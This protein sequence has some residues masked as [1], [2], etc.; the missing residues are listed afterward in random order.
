M[1]FFLAQNNRPAAWPIR[2]PLHEVNLW[3]WDLQ[4]GCCHQGNGLEILPAL[5]E[6]YKLLQHVSSGS[7]VLGVRETVLVGKETTLKTDTCSSLRLTLLVELPYSQAGAGCV[8]WRRLRE[9]VPLL[10]TQCHAAVC[11]TCPQHHPAVSACA[12]NKPAPVGGRGGGNSVLASVSSEPA[13]SCGS[14]SRC[15]GCRSKQRMRGDALRACGLA[16][17]GFVI[18]RHG[19]RGCCGLPCL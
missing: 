18:I 17:G 10:L 13:G 8:G 11:A 4:S 16:P 3:V 19:K 7:Q 2:F 5:C 12:C 9:V 1:Y 14:P 6:K 15:I